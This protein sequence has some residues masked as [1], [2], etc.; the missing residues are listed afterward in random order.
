MRWRTSA[1][2]TACVRAAASLI[3]GVKRRLSDASSVYLEERYQ[4]TDSIAGLTHA[5]GINL[6]AKRPL[7]PRRQHRLRHAE[8]QLDR[9]GN[10]PQGG[11]HSRWLWLRDSIQLSSAIEYRFDDTEQLDATVIERTTWLFRNNFK[12]QLTPDWRLV[13]KLNHAM[14]DSTQG[15]FYDGGYTEAVIGYAL[16]SGAQRSAQRARQVHLLLQR[17]DDRPGDVAG[18]GRPVHPEEPRRFAST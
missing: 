8:G 14:S 7:E 13:G 4:D 10:R 11:R 15:D 17:A 2:T 1:P 3:S 18:H 5:T 16:P 9:R 12:Y 6:V